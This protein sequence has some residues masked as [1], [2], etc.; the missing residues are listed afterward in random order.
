MK[1]LMKVFTAFLIILLVFNISSCKKDKEVQCKLT[2][3][4]WTETDG[5]NLYEDIYYLFYDSKGRLEKFQFDEEDYALFKYGSNG[6]L[7]KIEEYYGEEMDYLLFTWDGN[8]VTR[9]W[10]WQDGDGFYPSSSK[11][12]LEYNTK[13]QIIRM[14][15]L[16]YNWDTEDYDLNEYADF[17]WSG[18]NITQVDYYGGIRL[19]KSQESIGST[20][21]SDLR[22]TERIL[23][24]QIPTKGISVDLEKYM[25]MSYTYDKRNNPFDKAIGMWEPWAFFISKNNVLTEHQLYYPDEEWEDTYTYTYNNNNYPET[26]TMVDGNWI[27]TWEFSYDCK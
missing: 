3:W 16:Y 5:E 23:E 27:S 6:K 19:R 13:D 7:E 11:Y 4:K 22:K 18:G 15:R 20:R 21:P 12:V 9:Q 2:A 1:K 10:Y 25:T 24:E 26:M 17:T 14:N 8:T